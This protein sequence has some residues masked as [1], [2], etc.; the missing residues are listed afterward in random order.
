MCSVFTD[1]RNFLWIENDDSASEPG[2]NCA[3]RGKSRKSW[4]AHVDVSSTKRSADPPRPHA[5]VVN[6]AHKR[7]DP[8]ARSESSTKSPSPTFLL[9]MQN[10]QW[11][12]EIACRSLNP[13]RAKPILRVLRTQR[14][15]HD[16]T[17][18]LEARL[19]SCRRRETNTGAGSAN[20]GRPRSRASVTISSASAADRWTM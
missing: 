11:S 10:G 4:L 15:T 18:R 1:R 20:A 3:L 5:A 14:R 8:G 17:S 16:S 7:L 9:F 2:A 19:S 13:G 6:E 12:V